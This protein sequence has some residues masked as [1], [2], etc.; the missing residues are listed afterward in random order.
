MMAIRI[1]SAILNRKVY[2]EDDVY[3][4]NSSTAHSNIS[5]DCNLFG[6]EFE[7]IYPTHNLIVNTIETGTYWVGAKVGFKRNINPLDKSHSSVTNVTWLEAEQMCNEKDQNLLQ[8]P[9]VIG[10]EFRNGK[11]YWVSFFR[12]KNISWGEGGDKDVCAAI[13]IF[14]NRS[15]S[16]VSKFCTDIRAA[17]CYRTKTPANE[18]RTNFGDCNVPGLITLPL[19]GKTI[20]LRITLCINIVH[21]KMSMYIERL[22]EVNMR[23]PGTEFSTYTGVVE[24]NEEVNDS[25]YRDLIL[26]TPQLSPFYENETRQAEDSLDNPDYIVPEQHYH[27]IAEI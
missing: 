20:K 21:V 4:T 11:Y 3:I 1:N 16:L 17:L 2:D 5:T 9:T 15:V 14:P 24:N 23:L 7:A 22:N 13:T 18:G 10:H 26:H 25:A 27:T 19:A 12:K 6:N 8:R